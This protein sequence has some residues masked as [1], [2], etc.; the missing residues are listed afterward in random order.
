MVGL[1]AGLGIAKAGW[2]A[3]KKTGIGGKLAKKW[4]NRLQQGINKWSDNGFT[5]FLKDTATSINESIFDPDKSK[6]ATGWL[7]QGPA[8]PGIEQTDFKSP[9]ATLTGGEGYVFG[10]HP[11]KSSYIP[12][13]Y[14]NITRKYGQVSDIH[15]SKRSRVHRYN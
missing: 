10:T 14:S 3:F 15:K 9:A 7:P 2:D 13:D 4:G 6:G 11:N 12:M 1:I 5:G 8:V